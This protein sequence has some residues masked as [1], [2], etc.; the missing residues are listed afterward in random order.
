MFLVGKEVTEPDMEQWTGN[1]GLGKEYD[2]AVF[3]TCLFN[4]YAE[5]SMQNAGL[6]DSRA[7]IKT[8]RRNIS[9]IFLRFEDY[10]S[11]GRK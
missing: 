2:T 6:D 3:V 8:A 5:Y 11:S 9:K 1:S 4:L 7:G 10:H